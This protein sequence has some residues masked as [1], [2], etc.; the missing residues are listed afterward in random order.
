MATVNGIGGF[1]LYADDAKALAAWY[2]KH[3]DIKFED[4]GACQGIV[5]HWRHADDA[6][7]P[8]ITIFSIHQAKEKLPEG[9]SAAFRL[10][11]RVDD[12]DALLA[13]LKAAGVKAEFQEASDYGRF[14]QTHD[15]EG[16]AIELWQPPAGM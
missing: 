4:W 3:F 13:R 9:R 8:G 11:I 15:A 6:E 1:F 16:N 12:L 2:A 10:N 7:K 5:Y 14:G